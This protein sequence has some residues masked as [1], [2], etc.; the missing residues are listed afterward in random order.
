MGSSSN[1][2]LARTSIMTVGSHSFDNA[3]AEELRSFYCANRQSRKGDK[4][5]KLY[6]LL[7][8]GKNNN[9]FSQHLSHFDFCPGK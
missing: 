1:L 4:S 2:V 9:R 6:K 3:C 5:V 7:V 8:V